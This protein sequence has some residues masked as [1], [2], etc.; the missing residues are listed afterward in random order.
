MRQREKESGKWWGNVLKSV[1]F[2]YLISLV[3]LVLLAFLVLK[4]SIGQ[5][6]V[7]GIVIGIYV[8]SNLITG[9]GLGRQMKNRKFLWGMVQGI[10]Y[11]CILLLLS[12]LFGTEQM[13]FKNVVSTFFLCTGSGMIGG[14]LA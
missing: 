12:V 4:L 8:V 7:S 13:Q 2:S 11:F 10:A 14:M 3:L 1:V 9:R 5:K 6:V